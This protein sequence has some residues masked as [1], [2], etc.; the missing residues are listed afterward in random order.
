MSV[1]PANG[2]CGI[3]G[4]RVDVEELLGHLRGAHDLDV[5]PE[6]W[7]DGSWVVIDETL[8]PADFADGGA[9]E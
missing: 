4:E 8:E 9:A 3:C 7:P 5:E 1:D 6:T 2:T